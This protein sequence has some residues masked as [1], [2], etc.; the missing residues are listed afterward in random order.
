MEE[1]YGRE[2]VRDFLSFELDRY[3][4]GRSNEEV[5]EMPLS[6]VGDQPYIYYGK[7]AIVMYALKDLLGE[8]PVDRALRELLKAEGGP[9]GDATTRDLLERLYA[10]AP[11][12]LHPLI[13]DWF[14]EIALYD[15]KL[16]SA[17]VTPLAD[18]R[19]EVKM[20]IAAARSRA[21]GSGNESPVE[22]NEEIQV[23]IFDALPDSASGSHHVLYLRPHA[24][25]SG[26]NELSAVVDAKPAV[27]AVDPYI[28]RIDR[29][30]FDNLRELE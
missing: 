15:L 1:M 26:L 11:P 7:G 4:S 5:R 3:L 30:R 18:G 16:E 25:R 21:D 6:R 28:T 22:L 19:Y 29:S 12:T 8:E 14:A 17:A 13:N 23:G 24:L 9:G 27:V 2:R 20:R 10:V